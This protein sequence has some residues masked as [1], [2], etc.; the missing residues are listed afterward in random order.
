MKIMKNV[1]EN[2]KPRLRTVDLALSGLTYAS[3]S[4]EWM[5]DGW[6]HRRMDGWIDR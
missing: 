2:D 4:V 1:I 6:M 5:M 3:T